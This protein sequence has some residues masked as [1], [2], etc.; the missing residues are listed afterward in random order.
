LNKVSQHYDFPELE[1]T[2]CLY[3]SMEAY[4]Y[5]YGRTL[6]D[7]EKPDQKKT[8]KEIE[9]ATFITHSHIHGDKRH[10]HLAS[11]SLPKDW[12]QRIGL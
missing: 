2:H 11:S 6:K 9:Q 5:P 12:T 7:L 10:R 1:H 8:A 4:P 3:D